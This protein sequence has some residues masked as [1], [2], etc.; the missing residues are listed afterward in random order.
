MLNRYIEKTLLGRYFEHHDSLL[1]GI[2]VTDASR[3]LAW[4]IAS[5]QVSADALKMRYGVAKSPT[6]SSVGKMELRA[7]VELFA[8]NF[9][10]SSQTGL[11]REGKTIAGSL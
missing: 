3:V 4:N 10:T 11:S 6:P 9:T 1:P 8:Q 5:F 2:Q 7:R